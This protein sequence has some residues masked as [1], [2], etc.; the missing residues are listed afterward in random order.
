MQRGFALCALKTGEPLS[1][2]A[3]HAAAPIPEP[4][5]RRQRLGKLKA[6]VGPIL[7]RA[8]EATERPRALDAARSF[9]DIVARS[10][11]AWEAVKPW[12][13]H[14]QRLGLL[15][16]VWPAHQ[17]RFPPACCPRSLM[18]RTWLSGCQVGVC[19][20]SVHPP[21]CAD[22]GCCSGHLQLAVL[23]VQQRWLCRVVCQPAGVVGSL[24]QLGPASA[25]L[26]QRKAQR[27]GWALSRCASAE[28]LAGWLMRPGF[29]TLQAAQRLCAERVHAAQAGSLPGHMAHGLTARTPRRSRASPAG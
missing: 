3:Q 18:H 2:W 22:A 16:Q 27:A 10:T 1:C 5:L 28:P 6:L 26:Q 21:A 9:L 29:R 17:R 7:E 23:V 4:Q 20:I 25:S 12:V 11:N 8:S 13:N 24:M 19:Q 15:A 14:T